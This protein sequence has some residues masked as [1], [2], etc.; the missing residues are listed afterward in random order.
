MDTDSTLSSNAIVA[1]G[2]IWSI[3]GQIVAILVQMGS[4]SILSRLLS[5]DDFGA[6]AMVIAIVGVGELLRDF[7]LGNAAIQ[8]KNLSSD[9]STN[10]FWL[11]VG[12]GTATGMVFLALSG[13]IADF[14]GNPD[15]VL[16][17]QVLS[18]TFLINAITTQPQALL[19]RRLDVRSVALVQATAS[20]GSLLAAV[21]LAAIGWGYWALVGL[22][23]TRAFLRM[24]LTMVAAKFRPG[25]PN[26]NVTIAPFLRFGAGLFGAQLLNYFSKN[27]DSVMIGRTLG[28]VPLGFYSRAYQLAYTPT[29][30]MS[31]PLS[32]VALPTL[33]R[34]QEDP[35]RY[36]QFLHRSQTLLLLAVATIFGLAIVFADLVVRIA[37]GPGWEHVV[38]LLQILCIASALEAAHSVSYWIFVTLGRTSAHFQFALVTRPVLVIAII[39]VAQQGV[40]WVAWMFTA[41]IVIAWPVGLYWACKDTFV[42]FA[43]ILGRGLRLLAIGS[44]VTVVGLVSRYLGPKSILAADIGMALGLMVVVLLLAAVAL[45]H[46]REDV[47]LGIRS[48]KL[49]IKG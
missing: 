26:R 40:A 13:L 45:R 36:N 41:W 15:L 24:A 37:L 5:P 46:F 23:L 4:V 49:I 29:S 11:N 33:S 19:L 43:E 20:I 47:L 48:I 25:L 22:H 18:A 27:I 32:R 12:I 1:R 10:L 38:P 17:T 44:A 2:A 9:E 3:G 39:L 31:A 42:S 21:V 28:A 14:Y 30:Q 7:G 16:I 8:A 35:G 34:L 6:F